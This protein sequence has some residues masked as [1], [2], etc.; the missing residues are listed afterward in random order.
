MQRGLVSQIQCILRQVQIRSEH[1]IYSQIC[2][3]WG[4]VQWHNKLECRQI[5]VQIKI[6]IYFFLRRI[7]L[8]LENNIHVSGN[9]T[10]PWE[11]PPTQSYS[12]KFFSLTLLGAN[13][14]SVIFSVKET[15]KSCHFL[16]F[17]V[18]SQFGF[19]YFSIADC[20]LLK[21]NMY[22]LLAWLSLLYTGKNTMFMV[23][24]SQKNFFPTDRP[25][26]NWK[27]YLKHEYFFLGL[28]LNGF[29]SR[30]GKPPTSTN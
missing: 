24:C 20:F 10:E 21:A 5:W 13:W 14:F 11:K 8:G 9:L 18:I 1:R 2:K 25:P 16:C 28:M 22:G 23:L 29:E 26:K 6:S 4:I 7:M 27:S 30:C 19:S 17:N 3:S 15:G 12:E